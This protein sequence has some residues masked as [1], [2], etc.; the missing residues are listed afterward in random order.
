[1]QNE[2]TRNDVARFE[3]RPTMSMAAD[4]PKRADEASDQ[5]GAGLT[6]DIQRHLGHLLAAAYAQGEAELGATSRF[7]ELLAKLDAALGEARGRD[8]AEFKRLL[9]AKV[10][11][12]RRFAI[13]LA[14][15]PTG[16]DDLV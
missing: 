15:D 9:V 11:V 16:A 2:W 3:L 8:Y 5:S 14:R 13:S 1:L 12:L 6:D 4:E 10:P 7:A